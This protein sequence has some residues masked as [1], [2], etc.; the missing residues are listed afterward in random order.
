MLA[1]T[2]VSNIELYVNCWL[3]PVLVSRIA[4]EHKQPEVIEMNGSGPVCKVFSK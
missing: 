4:A 1:L 3:A 2:A